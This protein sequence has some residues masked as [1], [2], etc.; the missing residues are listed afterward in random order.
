MRIKADIRLRPSPRLRLFRKRAA[1]RDANGKR[2]TAAFAVLLKP[3]AT[4]VRALVS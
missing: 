1:D 2:R 3:F 4:P